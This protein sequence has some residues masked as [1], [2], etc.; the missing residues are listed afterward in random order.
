MRLS[1]SKNDVGNMLMKNS[2]HVLAWSSLSSAAVALPSAPTPGWT[3]LAVITPIASATVVASSNQR[4]ALSPTRPTSLAPAPAS[5]ATSVVNSSGPT[6]TR[7][8]RRKILL[9]GSSEVAKLGNSQPI[10]Q[11]T[12]RPTRI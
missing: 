2:L 8:M 3:R 7:I 11:P 5:P 1:A 9:I 10:R 4:I 12:T 6:S